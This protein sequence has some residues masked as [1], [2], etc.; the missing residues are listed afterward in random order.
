MSWARVSADGTLVSSYGV[1]S[2]SY[3][4]RDNRGSY[5]VHF[6]DT[7][8]NYNVCAIT[9]LSEGLTLTHASS[10]TGF[11]FFQTTTLAGLLVDAAFSCTVVCPAT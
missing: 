2:V 9:A 1:V 11:I 8:Q 3:N 10:G 6:T 7:D 4:P 5:G